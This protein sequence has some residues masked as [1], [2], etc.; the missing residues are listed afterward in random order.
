MNEVIDSEVEVT[1][2]PEQAVEA[3][4]M[5]WIPPERAKKM[6]EGK[7]YVGPVQFM[8]R[9]P[10]YN[11]VKKME[12][13]LSDV[14]SHNSKANAASLKKQEQEFND[15]IDLLETEKLKALDEADHE[16]VIKIDKELRNTDKPQNI[17]D[18]LY[19]NWVKNNT[20]YTDD[21]FLG[22]EADIVAEKYANMGL[23]GQELY[24]TVESHIKQS[25][26]TKFSNPKR[27]KAST[28]EGGSAKPAN[29][30]SSKT[31]TEDERIVFE[32]FKKM[33]IFSKDGAER[34]Y[35]N[36]VISLRE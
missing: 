9:N 21:K 2:T 16:K 29:K 8:E 25:H 13:V 34:D 19:D 35:I 20:W 15:K 24:D 10:L 27:E 36:E 17:S 22:V 6:P 3:E 1:W 23:Q 28:V 18:P 26:P 12:G 11:R 5:G 30:G 4:G 33:N 32:N 14:M 7:E 31:L